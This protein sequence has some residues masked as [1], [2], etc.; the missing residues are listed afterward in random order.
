MVAKLIVKQAAETHGLS[1]SPKNFTL[2]IFHFNMHI[3]NII[4]SI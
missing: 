3:Y 2:D 1:L 4:D